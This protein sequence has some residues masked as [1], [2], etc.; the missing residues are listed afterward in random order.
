MGNST[1]GHYF[2]SFSYYNLATDN[3]DGCSQCYCFGATDKC[4]SSDWGIEIV[5]NP[6]KWLVT[7]VSGS[8][9][10]SPGL[11]NGRLTVANDEIPSQSQNLYFWEAPS[12][13]LGQNLYSYGNSLKYI[14]NYVVVRGDTSGVYTDQPDVILEG[15]TPPGHRFG[16]K[17]H[18]PPSMN[19]GDLDDD[20][21]STIIM[22]LREQGWFKVDDDGQRIPDSQPTREEF[23]LLLYDLKRLLVR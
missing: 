22:P 12:D 15:S 5:R 7:D 2:L 3:P 4:K 8:F 16:F 19:N 9:H 6:Q 13:Y 14:V 23:T 11:E 18:K 20:L 10:H 21:N 1:I 17:W